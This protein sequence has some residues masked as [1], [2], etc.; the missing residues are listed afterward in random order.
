[1]TKL[2]KFALHFI[3]C[4]KELLNWF[5]MRR[6]QLC[7][8]SSL[9]HKS[10]FFLINADLITGPETTL[11]LCTSSETFS[12]KVSKSF[13][14]NPPPPT[15]S[16]ATHW[17]AMEIYA[18]LLPLNFPRFSRTNPL[19]FR[20]SSCCSISYHTL[21][22]EGCQIALFAFS[23]LTTFPCYSLLCI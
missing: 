15:P 14:S 12:F 6:G 21:I 16:L 10:H 18:S 13:K 23:S 20:A 19:C 2:T 11:V 17:K 9:I 7:T 3:L 8:L 5:Q 1:M 22:S 4:S